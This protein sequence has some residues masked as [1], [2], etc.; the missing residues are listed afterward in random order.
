MVKRQKRALIA[1]FTR[2]RKGKPRT[3]RTLLIT[4][5]KRGKIRAVAMKRGARNIRFRR[6]TK[7]SAIRI[8]TP[9]IRRLRRQGVGKPVRTS[10][11]G[12]GRAVFL[13]FKKRRKK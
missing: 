10:R 4:R 3:G 5:A 1:T 11:K 7:K 6:I 9:A 2:G 8:G 13:G 12:L